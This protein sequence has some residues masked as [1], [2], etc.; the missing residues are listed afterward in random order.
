VNV[1]AYYQ[2]ARNIPAENLIQVS[3]PPG[4]TSINEQ[5]FNFLKAQVDAERDHIAEVVGYIMA[6]TGP[7][8]DFFGNIIGEAGFVTT[9]QGVDEWHL[10][11]LNH[12]YVNPVVFMNMITANG[13]DPSHIRVRNV[14]AGSL[15]Y[16]IEEWDYRDQAHMTETLA[17]FVVEAGLHQMQ[18]GRPMEV[19]TVDTNQGWKPVT[20]SQS[21]DSAPV[22][23]SQCQTYNGWQAVTTRLASLNAASF[24]VRLQEEEGNSAGGHA[25]ETIGYIAVEADQ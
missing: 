19:G 2:Q 16:Q 17:Y 8:Y 3:F 10:L 7:M 18:D 4:S 23:L 14:G 21:F 22:T 12:S 25:I 24:Q 11:D 6:E 20:F 15:E 9:N 1:A 5:D 13:G